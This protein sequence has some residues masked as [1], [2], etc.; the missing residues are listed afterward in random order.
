MS[1]SSPVPGVTNTCDS[2][3]AGIGYL[4]ATFAKYPGAMSKPIGTVRYEEQS[5]DDDN[6]QFSTV[7]KFAQ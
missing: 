1:K 6:P 5:R 2:R 3:D 4:Q 7:S